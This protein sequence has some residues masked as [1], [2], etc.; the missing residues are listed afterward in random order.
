MSNVTNHL[1]AAIRIEVDPQTGEA[2]A[3]PFV[4]PNVPEG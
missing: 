3:R 4:Y 1:R 2:L